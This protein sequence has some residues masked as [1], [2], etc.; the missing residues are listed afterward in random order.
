MLHQNIS[1]LTWTPHFNALLLSLW[2]L[3]IV[4]KAFPIFARESIDCKD[5]F[6][7]LGW[8]SSAWLGQITVIIFWA[9]HMCSWLDLMGRKKNMQVIGS[10]Q[11]YKWMKP[12]DNFFSNYWK[13]FFNVF[14]IKI[15]FRFIRF[16]KFEMWLVRKPAEKRHLILFIIHERKRPSIHFPPITASCRR[17]EFKT[18]FETVS[19][20]CGKSSPFLIFCCAPRTR[21]L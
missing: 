8:F 18:N 16:K 2:A 13:L 4:A 11:A 5:I 9:T 10:Y 21:D 12:Y 7:T 6:R 3:A 14:F 17:A 19:A 15:I 1:V 20:Q